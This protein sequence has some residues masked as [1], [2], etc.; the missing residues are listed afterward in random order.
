M[1]TKQRE[2]E[3]MLAEYMKKDGFEFTTI[4]SQPKPAAGKIRKDRSCIHGC[5]V[6]SSHITSSASSV[7]P[8]KTAGPLTQM[9]YERLHNS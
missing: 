9:N 3:G 6:V 4:Q 5:C 1:T 7:Y 2:A 8:G